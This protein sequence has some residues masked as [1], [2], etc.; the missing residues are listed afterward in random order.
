MYKSPI[1]L[2]VSN[3]RTK[4]DDELLA[5]VEQKIGFVVDKEELLK[6]LRYDRDQYNKGYN[7]A[8]K[9]L[10]EHEDE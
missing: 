10:T 7:D 6:A 9:E 2:I 8:I 4:L 1:E 3:Y 5:T